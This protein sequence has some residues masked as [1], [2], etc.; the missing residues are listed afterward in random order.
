[1]LKFRLHARKSFIIHKH[2]SFENKGD[3]SMAICMCLLFIHL[4]IFAI[5]AQC[6]AHFKAFVNIDHYK[7]TKAMACCAYLEIAK[8]EDSIKC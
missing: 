3:L 8:S 1:M 6:R 2:L 4:F 5:V 7:Y